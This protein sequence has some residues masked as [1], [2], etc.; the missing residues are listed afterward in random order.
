MK[1]SKL[2]HSIMGRIYI[3]LG[4]WF[5]SIPW[6]EEKLHLHKYSLRY[7][8]YIP[9]VLMAWI[10]NADTNSHPLERY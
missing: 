9:D 4:K 1:L 2:F 8:A 10:E 7:L 5:W 6:I 3:L